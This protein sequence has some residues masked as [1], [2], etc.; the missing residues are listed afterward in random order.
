MQELRLGDQFVRYDRE[1]TVTAYNTLSSGG[2]ERCNCLYCRNFAAQRAAVYPHAFRTL[3]GQL[4]IDPDKEGEVYDAPGPCDMAIRPIGGWFYF[5]GELV[6]K[7]ER[8]IQD[9]DFQYWFQ[10]AFPKPPA[11][12]GKPVAAI[13]FAAQ[14]PWVLDETPTG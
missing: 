13:E 3:L 6:E 9:G 8:L 11:C 4:G 14:I 10:P 1:A 12:F 7:G 2:A 5:V